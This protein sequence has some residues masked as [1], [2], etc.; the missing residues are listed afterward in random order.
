VADPIERE[1][2]TPIAAP[3]GFILVWDRPLRIV[4][5]AFV[6][7]LSVAWLTPNTF[8]GLHRLAGYVVMALIVFRLAWGFAGTRQSRFR[9][10]PHLLRAAPRYVLNLTRRRAGRYLGLNPAGVCMA[11]ALLLL[12][13]ICAMSG[14]MQVTVRFFGVAWVQDLHT[15]SAYGVL[16]LAALHVL[17]VAF[18]S[19][20]Q[21]ENLLRSM[22][23]GRKRSGGS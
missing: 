16:S 1:K 3:S 23:T 18:M 2:A 5:W 6:A 7:A 21:R 10:Y 20:M 15:I 4:H 9:G 19:W 13:A 17:G 11:I 8:D 14:W 22:I 12:M